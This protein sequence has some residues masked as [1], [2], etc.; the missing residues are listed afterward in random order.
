MPSES[1][2]MALLS[3]VKDP[4]I[5]VLTVEDMGVIR[6]IEIDG[7]HVTVK[8]TPTYSGCPAMDVI[9][10]EVRSVLTNAGVDVEVKTIL[11]PPWTTD[12]ISE[13][14]KKKLLAVGIVPPQGSASKLSLTAQDPELNCPKC[15]SKNTQVISN[16]GSTA[17]K[18]LWK[19]NECLEPFEYFKCL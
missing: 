10:K 1:E 8:I 15:Q 17:C 19:C 7:N 16:F 6:S 5:P 3:S 11:S 12:W 9:E 13:H 18:A 2:I 14:G 4:E